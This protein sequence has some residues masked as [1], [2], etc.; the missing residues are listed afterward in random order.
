MSNTN[1]KSGDSSKTSKVSSDN[2]EV[3][4]SSSDVMVR[5]ADFFK[6]RDTEAKVAQ[7]LHDK[8]KVVPIQLAFDKFVE[9]SN[10]DLPLAYKTLFFFD[11]S[12]A[13]EECL[14]LIVAVVRKILLEPAKMPKNFLKA[15]VSYILN[16][17]ELIM[18]ALEVINS[19][20]GNMTIDGDKKIN[21]TLNYAFQNCKMEVIGKMIKQGSHIPPEPYSLIMKRKDM[22]FLD[23][24]AAILELSNKYRIKLDK[25][26]Y[27]MCL[28]FDQGERMVLYNIGINLNA[29]KSVKFI[30]DVISAGYTIDLTWICST[31]V[32]DGFDFLS[33]PSKGL[34]SMK[35]IEMI[36]ILVKHG[37]NIP[38]DCYY[39]V[40]KAADII[41]AKYL[42]IIIPFDEKK[43]SADSCWSAIFA[44]YSP[45]PSC[46]A[47]ILPSEDEIVVMAE[48]LNT[49]FNP[50][51]GGNERFLITCVLKSHYKH[52]PSKMKDWVKKNFK[53]EEYTY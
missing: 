30:A 7:Q 32:N 1:T 36:K 31:Y 18:E 51:I 40:C 5:I 46:P 12:L 22:T 52:M 9:L 29:E 42:Q 39:F 3:T 37:W 23:K 28:A 14:R 35:K 6:I 10:K 19:T 33:T 43:H 26:W 27:S 11:K 2:K 44:S 49:V 34:D 47:Q 16:E 25:E 17:T 8:L 48:W 15:I 13:K 41:V 50:N 45:S 53:E 24:V 20:S 21:D 38:T 4:V